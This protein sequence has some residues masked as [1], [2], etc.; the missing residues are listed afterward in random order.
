MRTFT[1]LS[2][3]EGPADVGLDVADMPEHENAYPF[4]G[5]LCRVDEESQRPPNGSDGHVVVLPLAV[6]HRRLGDLVGMPINVDP[7]SGYKDHAKNLPI[8]TIL[9]LQERAAENLL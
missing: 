2:K 6:V 4:T 1:L 9:A 5:T 3:G 8:G 7:D